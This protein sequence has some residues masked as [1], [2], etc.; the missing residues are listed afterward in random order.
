MSASRCDS[1]CVVGIDVAKAHLDGKVLPSGE[2]FHGPNAPSGHRQI[3]ARLKELAPERIVMEATG[4]YETALAS[5]LT[6]AGL[7]V[8]IVN[9]RLIR[10]FAQAMGRLAKT[11]AL[12][13]GVLADYAQKI[14]PAPRPLPDEAQRSLQALVSRHHQLVEM[15]AAE[16]NRLQQAPAALR[17]G[18]EQ[19]VRQLSEALAELEEQLRRAL[20]ENDRFRERDDLLRSVKGVGPKT[21]ALLVSALPE[22]GQLNRKKIAALV[23]LAPFN[24]DSG[25]R[26]GERHI[27]GGRAP[28]RA[29]LYMATLSAVQWNPQIKAVCDRLLSRGKPWKVMMVACMRKL[30]LL[31]NAIVKQ[32][33]P[34]SHEPQPT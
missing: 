20:R 29:V 33:K 24:D 21:S 9:P 16:K 8:V 30:L 19:H 1:Q 15:R 13:A 31:L 27:W 10:R 25:K 3:V 26:Q 6:A 14:A 22:L 5:A 28:I 32:G 17:D 2:T 4:G 12:D 34:W 7:P 23:G 11:D 18:I